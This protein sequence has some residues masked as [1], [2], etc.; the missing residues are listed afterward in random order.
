MSLGHVTLRHDFSCYLYHFQK[1]MRGVLKPSKEVQYEYQVFLE[2]TTRLRGA[3][4]YRHFGRR[5]DDSLEMRCSIFSRNL[6][7]R[8]KS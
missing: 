6:D 5:V 2:F 4:R 8:L 7:A 3:A 1:E